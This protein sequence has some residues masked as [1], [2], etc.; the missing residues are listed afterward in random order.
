MNNLLKLW[1]ALIKYAG[2]KYVKNH[3][4]LSGPQDGFRLLRTIHD[5]LTSIIMMMEDS[6]IYNKGIY[7]M[8]ADCKGA[9]N[10]SDHRIMFKHM[11]QVGMLSTLVDTCEQLYGVSTTNY[12]TPYGPTPS[13]D[14]N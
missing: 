10:A 8:Y 11:R 6:K 5:A 3:G 9:F 13:I 1:T 7:I 4:I 12:N 2:S 14:I